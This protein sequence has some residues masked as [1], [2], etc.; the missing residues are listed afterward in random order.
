[1]E[2]VK[3]YFNNFPASVKCFQTSDGF[4]FHEKGDAQMHTATLDDKEV[5]EHEA[6]KFKAS[7]AKPDDVDKDNTEEEKA[8]KKAKK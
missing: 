3:E 2:K 8:G 1:M 5:K 4:I 7:K 6:A